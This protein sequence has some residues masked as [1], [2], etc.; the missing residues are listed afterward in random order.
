M[1]SLQQIVSEKKK[2]LKLILKII[3]ILNL[4]FK[5]KI[6][7]LE[8]QKILILISLKIKNMLLLE[9]MEKEKLLF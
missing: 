8:N 1:M 4:L 9:K 6:L 3:S 5:L 7:I 2:I